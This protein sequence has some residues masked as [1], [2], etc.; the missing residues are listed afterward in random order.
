MTSCWLRLRAPPR[1]KCFAGH[2]IALDPPPG[3]HNAAQTALCWCLASRVNDILE[4]RQGRTGGPT[5]SGNGPM[6][7]GNTTS[8]TYMR[9]QGL[10]D[11][12]VAVVSCALDIC[13]RHGG[14]SLQQPDH[15]RFVA[16][17]T[18]DTERRYSITL[19]N[20]NH[21]SDVTWEVSIPRH[22]T[23]SPVTTFRS[24]LSSVQLQT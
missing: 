8:R 21:K 10:S 18:R 3:Y 7:A 4:E 16:L 19:R 24:K 17:S 1:T 15:D 12:C 13:W 23:G 9:R 20:G 5:P 2:S 6:K 11:T 22:R 14:V